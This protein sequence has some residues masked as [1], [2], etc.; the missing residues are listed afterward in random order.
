MARIGGLRG[1]Y[2]SGAPCGA[3]DLFRCVRCFKQTTVKIEQVPRP[4]IPHEE[5]CGRPVFET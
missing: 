1:W 5:E 3:E 2:I 4:P